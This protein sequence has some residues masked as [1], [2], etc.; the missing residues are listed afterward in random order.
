MAPVDPSLAQAAKMCP[1]L[2]K[3][4]TPTSFDFAPLPPDLP[5][6]GSGPIF[7]DESSFKLAYSLFHGENGVVPLSGSP[8][9]QPASSSFT[10][11][12]TVCRSGETASKP[13]CPFA[14]GF[15]AALGSSAAAISL[16]PFGPFGPFG[17]DAFR[18]RNSDFGKEKG[19]KK[20]EK[21]PEKQP[22]KPEP[23]VKSACCD[24]EHRPL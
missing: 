15:E 10:P 17:Y 2:S 21:R 22:E 5:I 12:A 7:E 3:I 1:F 20:Q 4:Q 16:S 8:R 14:N 6:V 13:G 9:G 11:N 18:S 24:V 23:E 19:K